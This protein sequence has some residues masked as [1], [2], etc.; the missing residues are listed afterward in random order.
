MD[1]LLDGDFLAR[2]KPVPG[3]LIKFSKV[4]PFS[5]PPPQL[6]VVSN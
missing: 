4:P 5:P 1:R 3:V 6:M 2:G